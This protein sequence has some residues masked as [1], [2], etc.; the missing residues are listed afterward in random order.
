[1][2]RPSGNG[3][4][5][6]TPVTNGLDGQTFWIV[7]EH[8]RRSA[9]VRSI[10]SDPSVTVLVGHNWLAGSA[11]ILPDD[12]PVKLLESIRAMRQASGHT[13]SLSS[14]WGRI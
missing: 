10:E 4:P 9:Y 13:P 2:V 6:R 12:D 11:Q 5:R 1:M 7:S 3:R 14:S 8:G